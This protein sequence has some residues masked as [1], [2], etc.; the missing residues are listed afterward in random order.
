MKAIYKVVINF[1]KGS[2]A[3]MKVFGKTLWEG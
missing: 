3:A 2:W 1:F